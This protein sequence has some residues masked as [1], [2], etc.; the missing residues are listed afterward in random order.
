MLDIVE[1]K[2]MRLINDKKLSDPFDPV[3]FRHKV[4]S[5]SL[6]NHYYFGH[7]SPELSDK[8]PQTYQGIVRNYVTLDFSSTATVSFLLPLLRLGTFYLL[9]FSI[10]LM[11]LCLQEIVYYFLKDSFLLTFSHLI[12]CIF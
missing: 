5:L 9:L 11:H 6:F 10:I 4:A 3:S 7:C 12:F 2:A 8:D 1:S